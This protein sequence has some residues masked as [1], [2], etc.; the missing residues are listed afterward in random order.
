VSAWDREDA[1]V[2]S[3]ILKRHSRPE[4]AALTRWGLVERYAVR[5]GDLLVP[6]EKTRK[7]AWY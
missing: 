7:I 4:P 6:T 1:L 5:R 3:G 2:Q